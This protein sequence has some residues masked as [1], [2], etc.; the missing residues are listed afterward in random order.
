MRKTF[1][2]IPAAAKGR[3]RK[4]ESVPEEKVIIE[5]EE[6]RQLM[7]KEKK[8]TENLREDIFTPSKN[9]LPLKI[10]ES[11]EAERQGI[12]TVVSNAKV[13]GKS[14]VEES[15]AL[16]KVRREEFAS[17]E[18]MEE[19]KGFYDYMKSLPGFGKF[20][21]DTLYFKAQETPEEGPRAYRLQ[22][23]IKGERIDNLTNE[24]LYKDPE[25]KGN[26]LEFINAAISAMEQTGKDEKNSP[27]F[28]G[29]KISANLLF[30]PRYSSNI[31]IAEKPD[32]NKNRIFLVDTAPQIQQEKGV[33]KLF[34][35]YIGRKLQIAQLKRWKKKI[36]KQK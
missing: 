35:K 25:I 9:E 4:K 5:D 10:L 11:K 26:L 14:D 29:S 3:K 32:K 16:K 31:I 7:E 27:D 28:Y 19:S 20:V 15:I 12:D 17:E 21:A 13:S 23:L 22:K 24:E 18:K 2:Q 1:E 34:Q 36:E 8:T 33:G 6:I 30:N